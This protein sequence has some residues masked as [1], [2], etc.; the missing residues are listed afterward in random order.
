MTKLRSIVLVALLAATPAGAAAQTCFVAR[1]SP[2]CSG[3]FITNAGLYFKPTTRSGE[4]YWRALVDWGVMV[5]SKNPRHAFG[6]SFF[7]TLDED[8][9][10]LGPVIRYRRWFDSTRSLDIAVGTPLTDGDLRSGSVLGVIKYNPYHWV[11]LGVR[12]E[13]ARH[14]VF[15]CPPGPGNCTTHIESSLRI[16]GG[17]ELGWVPGATLSIA[18]G[19]VLVLLI[20]ALAGVD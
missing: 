20:V 19:A 8:E 14:R 3:F 16:Y 2:Q 17:A 10:T 18:G 7:V 6:G 11:G 1:P 15:T 5:N 4:T 13:Y 12:P 9:L